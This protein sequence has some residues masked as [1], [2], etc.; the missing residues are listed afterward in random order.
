MRSHEGKLRSNLG[1]S[2]PSVSGQEGESATDG[3]W[4][5]GHV[6][7]PSVASR[8]SVLGHGVYRGARAVECSSSDMVMGQDG[9]RKGGPST[10]GNLGLVGSVWPSCWSLEVQFERQEP[11]VLG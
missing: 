5:T 6:F 3:F 2:D 9:G 7:T 1:E 8:S 4:R 11:L 10:G